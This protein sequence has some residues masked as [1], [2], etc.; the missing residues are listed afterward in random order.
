MFSKKK[1]LK[2]SLRSP[3]S[4]P[5]FNLE[6]YQDNLQGVGDDPDELDVHINS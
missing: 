2:L 5:E 6:L 4:W 3:F 1:F